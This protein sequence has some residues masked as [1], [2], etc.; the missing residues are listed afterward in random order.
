MRPL[1]LTSNRKI[2]R[3]ATETVWFH[4]RHIASIGPGT[5][6]HIAKEHAQ[7]DDNIVPVHAIADVKQ[8]DANRR[9]F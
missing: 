8:S 7:R 3:S 9:G 6:I 2:C 5:C 1:T 4:G